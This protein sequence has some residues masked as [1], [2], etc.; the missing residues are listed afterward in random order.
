M[1]LQL[2]FLDVF[3][4]MGSNKEGRIIGPIISSYP[5]EVPIENSLLAKSLEIISIPLH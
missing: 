5:G 4:L 2:F 3:T 1:V